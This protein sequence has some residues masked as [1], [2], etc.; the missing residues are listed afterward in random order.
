M[1][2]DV[3]QQFHPLSGQDAGERVPALEGK[4]A[5]L[6]DLATLGPVPCIHEPARSLVFDGAA[7]GDFYVAH[8]LPRTFR[9]SAQKST[10]NCS[11][12]VNVYAVSISRKC[13]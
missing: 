9:T 7:Y 8:L 2:A 12:L 4:P 1:S 3:P 13:R 11:T 10:I 5:L 6:E